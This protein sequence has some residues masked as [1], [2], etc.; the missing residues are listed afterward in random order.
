MAGNEEEDS[1]S[2]RGGNSRGTREADVA[3]WQLE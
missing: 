1:P 2:T 3:F